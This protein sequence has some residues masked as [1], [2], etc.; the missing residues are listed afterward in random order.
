MAPCRAN[1]FGRVG[2]RIDHDLGPGAGRL[3]M[4]EEPELTEPVILDGGEIVGTEAVATLFEAEAIREGEFR[5]G[6][7]KNRDRLAFAAG[8]C[9]EGWNLLHSAG[10]PPP[11]GLVFVTLILIMA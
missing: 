1:A 5:G 8:P 10:S 9:R 4:S 6:A 3:P 2:G 7:T 11:G